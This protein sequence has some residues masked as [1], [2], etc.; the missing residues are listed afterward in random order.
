MCKDDNKRVSLQRTSTVD[1][2]VDPIPD[3]FDI[4]TSEPDP[5]VRWTTYT[6]SAHFD[7]LGFTNEELDLNLSTHCARRLVTSLLDEHT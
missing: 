6:Y 7:L 2:L 1:L 3:L 4:F 5:A